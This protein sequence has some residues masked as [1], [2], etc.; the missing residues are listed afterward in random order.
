[1]QVE[2]ESRTSPLDRTP[3]TVTP[4]KYWHVMRAARTFVVSGAPDPFVRYI[5]NGR[6]STLFEKISERLRIMLY[7]LICIRTKVTLTVDKGISNVVGVPP[8]NPSDKKDL[9]AR[10][11]EFLTWILRW[12]RDRMATDPEEQRVRNGWDNILFP[13][14]RR[15][16]FD[17]KVGEA[18][19]RSIGDRV[20]KMWYIEGLCTDP[21]FQGRGY[22]GAVLDA[23]TTLADQAGQPTWV[24]SSNMEN[25]RFYNQH[26]FTRSL[27]EIRIQSGTESLSR[28]V[29]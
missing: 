9:V 17:E 24:G 27:L 4:L 25:T 11:A 6:K 15:K 18:V 10:F 20:E 28:S 21:S 29:L 8:S 13:P 14:F 19:K 3:V 23:V 16:E 1:M 7:L 2:E 26:G 12:S 5:R 22:G